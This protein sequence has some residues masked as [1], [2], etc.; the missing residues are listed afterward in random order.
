MKIRLFAAIAAFL[1]VAAFVVAAVNT[2]ASAAERAVPFTTEAFKA[3]QAANEPILVDVWASWCPTCKR[4][5]AVLDALLKQEKFSDLVVFRVD[6]DKQKDIVRE[7][8]APR[9]STLIVF[10]G[11]TE[12]G[13]AIA[14]TAE[15]EI[16][17]LLE[18]AY[19]KP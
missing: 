2:P 5:G 14:I 7:F 15:N 11:K 1:A 17:A 9:Q 19:P 13:R 16:E 4:Q 3:A 10:K 18:S 8:R 12:T 6:Y